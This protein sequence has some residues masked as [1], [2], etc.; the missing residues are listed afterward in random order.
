[1][2]KL[3]DFIHEDN[4][5]NFI[6]ME[7]MKGDIENKTLELKPY[8]FDTFMHNNEYVVFT[9]KQERFE[10]YHYGSFVGNTTICP[11]ANTIDVLDSIMPKPDMR[12]YVTKDMD[13]LEDLAST[14][15]QFDPEY[16]EVE[17]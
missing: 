7:S 16:E 3:T 9:D 1:M 6:D 5:V 13:N 8:E 17:L 15:E 12:D 4:G 10:C 2:S 14:S 11:T